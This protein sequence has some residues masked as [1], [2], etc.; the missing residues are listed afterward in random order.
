MLGQRIVVFVP[1]EVPRHVAQREGVHLLAAVLGHVG[2]QI[3]GELGELGGVVGAVGQLL[4]Q[5]QGITVTGR[6]FH[7]KAPFIGISNTNHSII[8]GI[9]Q[10]INLL[11]W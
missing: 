3:G 8:L 11:K 6:K 5:A 9:L 4:H 1:L 2:V 10:V 7:G